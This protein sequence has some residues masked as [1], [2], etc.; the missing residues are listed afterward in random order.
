[1]ESGNK[2]WTPPERKNLISEFEET[3]CLWNV[4]DNCYKNN[5][6]KAG[7]LEKVALSL[8]FSVVEIKRISGVSSLVN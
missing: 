6:M 2:K 8:G 5:D 3:P 1:M 7:A 4:F